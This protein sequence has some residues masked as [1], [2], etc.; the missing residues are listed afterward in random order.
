MKSDKQLKK[1]FKLI[2]SK[3]PDEYYATTVLKREGFMRKRCE[4]KTY[5]WTTH[6]DRVVCGDPACSGG[7]DIASGTPAKHKLSFGGVWDKI[8]EVLEPRGYKPI[9]RYP[10]V[11]RWNPTMEYTLASIAAFQPYVISGDVKPPAKK[12]LIPQFCLRFGDIDNVGITGSHC[13]GFVMIGQHQ[14]VPPEEWSQ[15]DAFQDM[16]DFITV[17]VGLSK[18]ELTLHEDA[19]AGGGNYGPCM[20]FFSRGV[21]LFNQVY[22]LYELTPTGE[23]KELSIKVL[24][25]G[26]GMERVA[27]FSQGTPNMYE[28][29]FPKVL[30]KL[31]EKT[32]TE[33]DHELYKE[34]SRYSAYLNVDES[35]NIEAEWKKVADKLSISVETLKKKVLPMAAIY[36]IAEHAR[37]LLV[38]LSDGALP[39]NTGG[40]YNLRVILR[41]ALSFIDQFGWKVDLGE[42]AEWHAKELEFVFP[43]L[44]NNLENV[45]KILKV[46][47]TKYEATKEKAKTII[48]KIVR[49]EINEKLL[50]QLYDS[51]GIS[52]EIIKE[53]ALKHGKKIVVPDDFYVKVSELH[54]KKERSAA[55]T[56]KEVVIEFE[57]GLPDTDALYFDDYKLTKF[58][59]KVL[60]VKDEYVV[61]DQTLY[62]PTSGGQLHDIGRINDFEVLDVFKQGGLIIHRLNKNHGL[63]KG[64]MISGSLDFDRRLQLTQHHSA[65]HI[66]NAAARRILG[67]HVYQAGAR[68]TME[69][70][71]LDITHYDSLKEKELKLIEA[72]AN[73]LVREAHPIKK[74]FMPRET[75]EARHGMEIYQGGAVPG[76]EIRIVEVVGVDVEACGGTHLDNTKEIGEIKIIKSSKIQDGVVRLEFTAGG[77]AKK[78]QDSQ[79]Y[80][81]VEAQ[82]IL[83]VERDEIISAATQL[84]SAWKK[85]KKAVSKKK[86]VEDLSIFDIN[87]EKRS[88]S[89][90]LSVLKDI[91][92][93]QPEHI[94]KTLTRFKKELEQNIEKIS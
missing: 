60:G 38:S 15:E 78:T 4:C 90:V 49:Q 94:P 45:K 92:R 67:S 68:K 6:Q 72:E 54:A 25:M 33:M 87:P 1:E 77:T 18:H 17:G 66:V 80:I 13:T 22:M 63:K 8:V 7:F 89:D 93:T 51:N 10:T 34:F 11:A 65:T 44:K 83:S 71:T 47:K 84:F 86:K 3:N 9:K 81:L 41:R 70:S 14:F 28:A 91:L 40:G 64:D 57:K 75:A 29:I 31:R 2:A 23:S 56:K 35:E 74:G 21:E 12:L 32:K 50:L 42:V 36:S 59:A 52:P 37:A 61:L 19:W 43:E 58:E 79:D 53:E 30:K 76:S 69:K 16:Y 27:W 62:Y 26:L 73:K 20:E 82:R 88:D 55:A 48:Q 39:S 24:D 85:A 46:E 5:F